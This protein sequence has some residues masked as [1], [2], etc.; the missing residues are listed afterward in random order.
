MLARLADQ[1]QV[2]EPVDDAL[3]SA[4]SDAAIP[5]EEVPQVSPPTLSSLALSYVYSA[6]VVLM[7]KGLHM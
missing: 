2:H 1:Q 4:T 5:D 3:H 7:T 6:L